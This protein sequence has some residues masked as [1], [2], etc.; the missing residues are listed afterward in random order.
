MKDPRER[1][2]SGGA[3]DLLEQIDMKQRTCTEDDCDRPVIAKGRCTRHY[4]QWRKAEH[5]G[6]TCSVRTCGGPV[7]AR[8]LCDTHYAHDRAY[9]DPLIT[10]QI[11]GDIEA[12]FWSFVDRRGDDE[13][14]PWTGLHHKSGHANFT[15][16]GKRVPA[17]RWAYERFVGPIP[18]G[19][20]IDHVKD[21]GC[22]R[23]DCVNFLRHLEPVTSRVNTLR[24]DSPPAQNARKTHCIHGHEF[25]PENTRMDGNRRRCRQ[26]GRETALAY[27]HRK[28]AATLLA[29]A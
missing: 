2:G 18:D 26:C 3:A 16:G 27:Y 23:R 11:R 29:A 7:V 10:K 17:H 25:T 4:Q 13:C 19:L 24:G 9:G 22:T 14:W 12:R 20:E 8:G 6:G 1:L 5:A 28:R 21:N 15:V